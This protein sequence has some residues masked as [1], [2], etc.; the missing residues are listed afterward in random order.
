[1]ATYQLPSA[2]SKQ[3]KMSYA[4][5]PSRMRKSVMR[6]LPSAGREYSAGH[7]CSF[8][9]P[10]ALI[11]T[12]TI[13]LAFK[14]KGTVGGTAGTDFVYLPASNGFIEEISIRSAGRVVQTISSYNYLA[15]VLDRLKNNAGKRFA[16]R[17]YGNG[18]TNSSQTKQTL[19]VGSAQTKQMVVDEFY[20]ILSPECNNFID[21]SI[22]ADLE[23]QIKFAVAESV[24]DYTASGSLT[25]VKY[26]ELELTFETITF[27]T[28]FLRRVMLQSLE[29]KGM[30]GITYNDWLSYSAGVF[31]NATALTTGVSSRHLAKLICCSRP[32]SYTA[33]TQVGKGTG[34]ATGINSAFR[35]S[36]GASTSTIWC[37]VGQDRV[38]QFDALPHNLYSMA[39]S[40]FPKS[41][42]GIDVLSQAD[43]VDNTAVAVINMDIDGTMQ[44]KILTGLDT[45]SYS[46]TISVNYAGG[47]GT[48]KQPFVFIQYASMY[49]VDKN[50]N[51]SIGVE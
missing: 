33:T 46:Q 30:L 28:D 12:S 41:G 51:V 39:H 45:S 24:V 32:A 27:E 36:L 38:P 19:G 22:M 26:E 29:Q 50:G 20:G 18:F 37:Q 23:L 13:K 16:E 5:L 8:K 44:E 49:A 1:M 9:F 35:T 42:N 15:S 34:S 11:D 17:A 43:W 3:F 14:L 25:D 48:N 10:L 7:T 21:T 6:V 47:S 4:E 2:I 40:A 31:T